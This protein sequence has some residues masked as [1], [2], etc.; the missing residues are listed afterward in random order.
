MNVSTYVMKFIN[1]L[2]ELMYQQLI[3]LYQ[4]INLFNF[5][6]NQPN[7]IIVTTYVLEETAKLIKNHLLELKVN[8][9]QIIKNQP[10]VFND[11]SLYFFLY[12]YPLPFVKK[13]PKYYIVWQIEQLM[14]DDQTYFRMINNRLGIFKNANSI[15][16]ICLNNY[17]H[18]NNYN[19]FI[20][21]SKLFYVPLPFYNLNN[22][23]NIKK[24]IDFVFFG[25]KSHRRSTILQNLK[26]KLENQNINFEYYFD[27]YGINRD[28]ILNKSKYILNLHRYNHESCLEGDRFN[29][30]INYNCLIISEDTK[31]D[32]T[33]KR[34][35]E[36]FVT[37]FDNISQNNLEFV[38]L[39]NLMKYLIQPK[40]YYLKISNFD[41]HK[42]I[43][44]NNCLN[45]LH[46]ALMNSIF[47]NQFNIVLVDFV[48]WFEINKN[49]PVRITSINKIN[50]DNSL[51]KKKINNY[52]DSIDYIKNCNSDQYI[53]FNLI[54]NAGYFKLKKITIFDNNLLYSNNFKLQIQIIN[55][56]LGQN[57]NW[58]IFCGCY[59]YYLDLD[60]KISK[61]YYYK[62]ILFLKINKVIG[63]EF[64]IYHQSCFSEIC[65]NYQLTKISNN[66]YNKFNILNRF[67]NILKQNFNKIITIFPPIIFNPKDNRSFIDLFN[68]NQLLN[69]THEMSQ[70]NFRIKKKISQYLKHNTV[71]YLSNPYRSNLKRLNILES[72]EDIYTKNNL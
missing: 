14:S 63:I 62:G 8:N 28:V 58:S 20:P 65:S 9:I 33:T 67:K 40:I 2:I 12:L 35:Y 36:Y 39:I 6:K 7:I 38:N 43:L 72:I 18:D 21:K 1:Q 55:H 25:T 71:F 46:H 17:Y 42:K 53:Y 48:K 37:Y 10:Y 68:N 45:Y 4:K 51:I 3:I 61:I 69:S 49:L 56:F 59:D 19:K 70:I 32:K 52:F 41:Y 54:W 31:H 5:I 50:N 15:F 16:D 44:S 22:S 34:L 30:A 23:F 29:L 13:Y 64:N 57:N 11:Y 26:K 24:D 47:I 60:F 27:L 66:K